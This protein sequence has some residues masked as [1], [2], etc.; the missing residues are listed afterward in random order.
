MLRKLN[1]HMQENE[2]DP[3]LTPHIKINSK[4]LGSSCEASAPG[5]RDFTKA[6]G[7]AEES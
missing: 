6:T 2:I 3:Y 1:I 7:K 5:A 4:C